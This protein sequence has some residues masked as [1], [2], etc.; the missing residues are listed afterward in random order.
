M[1]S[2]G[3]VIGKVSPTQLLVMGI[4]EPMFY[5]L[6]I[7]LIIFKLEALDI[8]GGMTIHTFGAYFGLTV[9]WFVTNKVTKEHP[10]NA[11]SYTSDIFSLAGTIFLWIMWPSFNAAIARPGHGELRA[12]TNTFLS[13][14]ASVLSSF[15]ISRIVTQGNKLDAVH[16]QN[17]TLAG[18]VAMGVAADLNITPGG[19]IACGFVVGAISVMGYRFLTPWMS[20]KLR[21]Q[22]ICGIHNLHGMPGL[23]SSFIGV[24]AALGASVHKAPYEEDGGYELWMPH[25]DAQAGYQMA[26]IVITLGLAVIGGLM[27]GVFMS[28]TWKNRWF[29]AEKEREDEKYF[30]DATFWHLP[31]SHTDE[32]EE[33]MEL[34]A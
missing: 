25:K 17:S 27:M 21:I 18:G 26:G 11:P 6:N 12:L 10:G 13:I 8:G 1:I 23:C 3:G 14:T 33:A 7:Y 9:T 28:L 22:D 19:A 2:F 24:F 34:P 20:K 5:W 32:K 4:L 16:I 15:L 30:D 31:H 29:M